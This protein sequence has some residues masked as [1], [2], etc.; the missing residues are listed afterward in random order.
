MHKIKHDVASVILTA[1][2][3]R[4]NVYCEYVDDAFSS[5]TES[6]VWLLLLL[7][8]GRLIFMSVGYVKTTMITNE[9]Q[10]PQR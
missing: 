2:H 7:N 8:F 10:Q 9:W 6:F 1:K 4:Q 5:K 3:W